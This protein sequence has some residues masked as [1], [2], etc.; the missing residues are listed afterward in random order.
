LSSLQLVLK[1]CSVVAQKVKL[2]LV[3]MF[4]VCYHFEHL[5]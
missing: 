1:F 2:F 3:Q 5:R 4:I